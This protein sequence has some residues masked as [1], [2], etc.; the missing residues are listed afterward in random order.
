MNKTSDTRVVQIP[1]TVDKWAAL[2]VPYPMT[3]AMWALMEAILKAMKP[4]LVHEAEEDAIAS[5]LTGETA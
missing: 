3:D 5:E 2:Q 4:G 1:L